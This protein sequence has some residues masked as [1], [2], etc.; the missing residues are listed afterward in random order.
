MFKKT[1]FARELSLPVDEVARSMVGLGRRRRPDIGESLLL[2]IVSSVVGEGSPLAEK[3]GKES[4][5]LDW[6]TRIELRKHYT[7]LFAQ[8]IFFSS[9]CI[10]MGSNVSLQANFMIRTIFVSSARGNA[11]KCLSEPATCCRKNVALRNAC[12]QVQ[13]VETADYNYL[14]SRT[15]LH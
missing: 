7:S 6:S 9:I 13:G 3:T 14:T 2:V 1:S 15:I 12:A 4:S 5:D 8:S 10:F 11:L